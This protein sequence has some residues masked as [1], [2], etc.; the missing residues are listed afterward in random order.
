VHVA[1][2]LAGAGALAWLVASGKTS[3]PKFPDASVGQ[4]YTP[5]QHYLHMSPAGWV[6]HYPDR[7]AP[8]C[9]PMPYQTQD[10]GV[11]VVRPE[12]SEAYGA[13]ACAQ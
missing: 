3:R 7:T 5:Y 12:V 13:T 11:S 9:L 6:R 4:S 8:T 1:V 2:G 10:N